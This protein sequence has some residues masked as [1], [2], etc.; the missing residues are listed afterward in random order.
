MPTIL[1]LAEAMV[2]ETVQ[3]KSLIPLV[4]GERSANWDFVVTS[5]P[6]IK[7]GETTQVVDGHTR[8]IHQCLPSTVTSEE[9]SLIYSIEGEP[10]ELYYLPNDSKQERNLLHEKNDVASDLLAKF[11]SHL[12]DA[13]TRS[14]LV[15]ARKHL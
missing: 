7:Q 10:A 3:A 5:H 2:P 9:W 4:R 1:E 6:L 11:V 12:R 14:D 13:K 15:N 8:R